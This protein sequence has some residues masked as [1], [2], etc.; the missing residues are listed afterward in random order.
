MRLS[1]HALRAS[2]RTASGL[3]LLLA[4]VGTA[5]SPKAQAALDLPITFEEDINYEIRDF[6]GTATTLVADPTDG[7]NM[8]AQTVRGAGAATFAGT[9]VADVTGLA[10][11]VPFTADATTMSMRVWSPRA[12]VPV[13]L[14]IE[15]T[16]G[17]AFS[18]TETLTTVAMQWETLVFDFAAPA[19]GSPPVNPAEAYNKLV[20]FF[21]FGRADSPMA[22]T[23]YWDDITFGGESTSGG[24]DIALPISFE[25][26]INYELQD[27]GGTEQSV[28]ITDPT[29]ATNRVVQTTRPA[30]A[31]CFAGT[32]VA[33][34]NGFTERI[35]FTEDE[36]RMSVRVWS[37]EA[38]ALVL[39][40][41]EEVGNPGLNAETYTYTTVAGGW[42]TMV[43]DF[44]DPKPNTNPIQVGGNYNKASIFFD[45]QCD[46]VPASTLPAATRTYY[47]D[48]VAFGV[49]MGGGTDSP[50]IITGVFDG[51]LPGGIPKAIEFYVTE[52]IADLSLY[53]FGSANNG[54]DTDGIEFQFSGSASAGDYLYAASETTGF[55]QFFGFAP[56]FDAGGAAGINGD[57]AIELFYAPGG[58]TVGGEGEVIDVFGDI[59]VD[60]SGQPWEYL[61]GWAYRTDE[62]GPDGSSFVIGN[63]TFSGVDANDD[64]TAQGTATN[65]WPIGTYSDGTVVEGNDPVVSFE[66]PEITWNEGGGFATVKVRID[67][68]GG[69]PTGLPVSVTIGYTGGSASMDDV[70]MPTPMTLTF[71]G[72]T[73]GE[74][75]SATLTAVGNDGDEPNETALFG[76][77][78]TDG[79]ATVGDPSVFTFS[80]VDTDPFEFYTIAD[81]RA[82]GAGEYVSIRATVTRTEG[83]F[84]YIQ[85]ATGALTIRQTSGGFF[86][87]VADG[88][89][90]P[91]SFIR[92]TGELS[93]FASL[94]QINDSDLDSYAVGGDQ[95]IPAA[96]VVTLAELAANGEAYEAELVTVQEV[97]IGAG[98]NNGGIFTERTTYAITDASDATGAVSLRV[99]N[100]ADTT[101]DGE[102]VPPRAD[103]TAVVGQF[104]FD[105]PTTGYQLLVIEAEDIEALPAVAS[106]TRPDGSVASLTVANPLR[107]M[108]TVRFSAGTSSEVSVALY[109]MLGRRVATLVDGPVS[110][111]Q[112]VSL[113][114]TSL[115]S[116]VYVLRMQTED[117]ALTETVTVV[118]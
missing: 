40:K 99:P 25:E 3:F 6:E 114:A 74:I 102:D 100:A 113:D 20:A 57:D 63:W 12:G 64:D 117:V 88:S 109:D 18:E 10:T 50:L 60:G 46:N 16:A 115:S 54:E 5:A 86:D 52:D 15:Q 48:D 4:L 30:T 69:V 22:E 103:V 33:D 42:E 94:L 49:E 61:D 45:F 73:D 62:T 55:T 106:E 87:G 72:N 38:G 27:F 7:A 29:D 26:D 111:A 66:T 13:R 104:N 67:F 14:K 75:L 89:I 41:V 32:T 85:D 28:I 97:T 78:V 47:W 92:V 98:D 31:E 68:D 91:G 84:T 51:P 37:P 34:A 24:D 36:Q 90:H 19:A 112:T 43:F 11:P 2:Y 65:P 1:T 17:G 110:G 58:A 56:T 8:V 77:T 81:A 21:D 101:V 80:I 83:A 82:L 70:T 9:V 105:D 116:G 71:S 35:P 53:G 44:A 107:G 96:Q 95:P 39:F 59:L 108:A 93:E 118:R 76:L 23:F 79:V